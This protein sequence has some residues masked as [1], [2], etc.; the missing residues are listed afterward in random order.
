V[1]HIA[2]AL[3]SANAAFSCPQGRRS[4][5]NSC[6][7][8]GCNGFRFLPGVVEST[9]RQPTPNGWIETP[10]CI[11]LRPKRTI[12]VRSRSRRALCL[13]GGQ[14]TECAHLLCRTTTVS[15]RKS[16]RTITT[17]Q[18]RHRYLTPCNRNMLPLVLDTLVLPKPAS[19]ECKRVPCVSTN[20][21]RAVACLL[22]HKI[23]H[24]YTCQ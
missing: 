4:T 2:P 11:L 24:V 19:L 18:D 13:P 14:W 6:C 22:L 10:Q 21:A 7:F 17:P 16:D 1:R 20:Q 12:H 3:L 8:C 5:Q 23:K 15:H 9:T